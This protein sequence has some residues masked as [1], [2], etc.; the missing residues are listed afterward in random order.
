MQ[1]IRGITSQGSETLGLLQAAT[2][3]HMFLQA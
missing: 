3:S 1:G 2:M